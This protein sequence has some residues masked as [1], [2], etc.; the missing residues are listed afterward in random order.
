MELDIA[1]FVS[2]LAAPLAAGAAYG[3][4]RVGLNGLKRSV[5]QIERVINRLDEKVDSHSERLVAVEAEAVHIKERI[6]D[7]ASRCELLR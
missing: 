6:A 5:I 1:T 7:A 4:C 3:G 2:L